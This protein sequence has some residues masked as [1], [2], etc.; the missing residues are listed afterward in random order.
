MGSL[1]NRVS[2]LS[3]VGWQNWFLA[4]YTDRPPDKFNDNFEVVREL[5]LKIFK[6]VLLHAFNEPK[7][8]WILLEQTLT[9]VKHFSDRGVVDAVSIVVVRELSLFGITTLDKV[10]FRLQGH[11]MEK[12]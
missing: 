3:L 4:I 10:R 1:Q 8:G 2:I 5:V 6:V 11:Y 7:A 9:V 12:Y